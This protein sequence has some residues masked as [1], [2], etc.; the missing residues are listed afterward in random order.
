MNP[1]PKTHAGVNRSKE[2]VSSKE[3]A[4]VKIFVKD[5]SNE[6][7]SSGLG[8]VDARESDTLG[9]SSL[10]ESDG[11]VKSFT[12]AGS[13]TSFVTVVGTFVGTILPVPEAAPDEVSCCTDPDEGGRTAGLATLVASFVARGVSG[14]LATFLSF[15][16]FALAI[17]ERV[18]QTAKSHKSHETVLPASF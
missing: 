16:G 1:E 11:W 17:G 8:P 18:C 9:V 15:D 13:T 5:C 7:G 14:G 12:L 3:V 2:S 6:V 4:G 10:P